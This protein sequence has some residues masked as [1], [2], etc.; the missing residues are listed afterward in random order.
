[1]LK[2]IIIFAVLLL[3]LFGCASKQ[4]YSEVKD[5]DLVGV[6]YDA[7]DTLQ[8]QLKRPLPKNS[9]I[10]VSTLLNV[11]NLKQ[12]SSFG[13]IISDQIASAL[14]NAGYQIIGMELPIDLF[15]MQDNGALHLP[16]EVKQML[17]HYNAGTL[18]GG[19]YAPGKRNAYISLRVVDLN[20]KNIISSTDLSV[21]MGPDAKVLLESREVG[22]NNKAM[23]TNIEEASIGV[24]TQ[25]PVEKTKVV[26]E[27]E[28]DGL[29]VDDGK[30]Q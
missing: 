10:I 2:Q 15:V 18:V 21:P 14:H 6:S 29:P 22:S 23:D 16:D 8:A 9:L 4:H 7:V 27:P 25:A 5:T 11:D 1:M 30:P 12:T 26:T 3:S 19:V 13:R 17:K 24:K 28:L 20:T